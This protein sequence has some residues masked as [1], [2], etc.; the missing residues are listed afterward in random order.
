M[1]GSLRDESVNLQ[2][3]LSQCESIFGMKNMFP[4]SVQMNKQ[5]GGQFPSQAHN[6]F[7]SDFSDDPWQRASVSFPPA[8]DQP[9][10]LATCDN[11]G[12]CLDFHTATEK[13]PLPLQQLRQEF[14]HY[15][16]LW[17]GE[18]KSKK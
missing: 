4:S 16:A 8:V 5:F 13:D 15:L 1:V 6:V 7:Y 2:Y 10:A 9:Y 18:Y 11:C 3:H 14:E 12:H 17:L